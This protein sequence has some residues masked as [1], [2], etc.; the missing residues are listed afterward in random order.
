MTAALSTDK[1]SAARRV[2][3]TMRVVNEYLGTVCDF[4]LIRF[5]EDG[6]K[7]RDKYNT[8][9]FMHQASRVIYFHQ[10]VVIP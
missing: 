4:M 7:A 1:E 2:D 6:G 3:F 10:R 8:E 9:L 5:R